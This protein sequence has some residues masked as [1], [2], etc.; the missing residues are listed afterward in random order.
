MCRSTSGPVGPPFT[1]EPE[2]PP[3]RGRVPVGVTHSS[4]TWRRPG[5]RTEESWPVRG[6]PRE[7]R[8]TRYPVRH[9]DGKFTHPRPRQQKE[10]SRTSEE[11]RTEGKRVPS[12]PDPG[13][14]P[15]P[16]YPW[17]LGSSK[18]GVKC[19]WGSWTRRAPK[20]LVE[21]LRTL[22][23]RGPCSP[24]CPSPKDPSRHATSLFSFR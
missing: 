18:V 20:G 10:G 23:L 7:T 1:W 21:F 3:T 6:G 14:L 22:H 9:V 17:T 2:S 24:D 15:D 4:G 8:G 19:L 11:A 5:G 13:R 16:Y 12:Q